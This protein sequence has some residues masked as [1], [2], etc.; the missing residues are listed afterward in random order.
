MLE[1][2]LFSL[3]ESTGDAAFSIT[4]QG[5]ICSWNK[6]A[7]T[8]FGYAAKE[9]LHKS[10]QQVLAGVGSLGTRVCHEGCVVLA[11]KN[12]KCKFPNFDLNVNVR[13]GKR[14]W[15]NVSTLVYSNE[16]TGRRLLVHIAHDITEQ[17]QLEGLVDKL[18]D[19]AQQLSDCESK[20]TRPGPII[21]LS[22][23]EKRVL[24]LFSQGKTSAQTAKA[25]GI[26]A[27]TLRNHLHHINQKLRTHSRLEAVMHALQRKLI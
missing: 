21:S 7:E 4:E 15:I 14:L 23:Q 6:A 25:L 3:L 10:C 1:K 13:S 2:E 18:R 27:Q 8:L 19:F 11:S 12:G 20:V 16:R 26:S 24:R 17:K 5:E 22:E 9:V